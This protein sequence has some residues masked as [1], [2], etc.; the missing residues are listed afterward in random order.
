MAMLQNS[1]CSVQSAVSNRLGDVFGLNRLWLIGLQTVE[2]RGPAQQRL[3]NLR[4]FHPCVS[5]DKWFKCHLC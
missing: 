5:D 2:P 3:L 4:Q 1:I